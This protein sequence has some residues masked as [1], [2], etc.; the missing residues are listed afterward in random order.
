MLATQLKYDLL[1]FSRELFYLIFIVVIPP[2]TYLFMGQLYG[3]FTY[4]DNLSYG[5]VY[6]PSFILLISFSVIFFTFGFE[7]VAHRIAG[8]E[9]RIHLSPVP[10][11][12]LLISSILKSVILTSIGFF[13]IYSI[14][15]INYGLSFDLLN[16]INSYGFFILLNAILLIISTAIYSFFKKINSALIFSIVIFQVVMI[17]GGFSIPVEMMPEMIAKV[18]TV[19]PIYHMNQL[20]IDVWN[21]KLQFNNRTLTSITYVLA[22]FIPALITM[23]VKR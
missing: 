1:M 8:I 9:K 4:N 12:V 2:A 7:Q 19:N 22:F 5:Q 6:T 15:V 13:I 3:N 10:R 18:A 17:T 20:F 14:G 23:R 21:N 16:L 11:N